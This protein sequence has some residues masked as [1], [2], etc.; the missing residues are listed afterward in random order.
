ELMV[1]YEK[2]GRLKSAFAVAKELMNLQ[3]EMQEKKSD[4][5]LLRLQSK[6]E[7]QQKDR[8]IAW[9]K[10][11]VQQKEEHNESLELLNN[12]LKNFVGMASHDMKEPARTIKA[13]SGILL[14]KIDADTKEY[15][16]MEFINSAS[17]RMGILITDLLEYA[18]AGKYSKPPS[19][20]CLEKNCLLALNNMRGRI[21]ETGAKIEMGKLPAVLAH[22]TPIIQLFQNIMSNGIKYGRTD[23]IPEIKVYEV[24]DYECHHIVIEDNGMGIP[25]NKWETIFEPFKRLHD[26]S[27]EKGSGIGLAT[28]KKILGQYHGD[29]YVRSE[30]GKGSQFHILFP[31]EILEEE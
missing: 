19:W 6:M 23:I 5:N 3:K 8:E 20:V 15:K 29:I 11:M 24:E 27:Y 1:V 12:E 14:K 16:Y 17:E 22:T 30:I 25:E 9:Q 18:H 26:S 28:C 4:F 31:F 2:V 10:E 13:Y 21:K 7:I